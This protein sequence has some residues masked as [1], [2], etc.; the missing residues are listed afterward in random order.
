MRRE[1]GSPTAG[2]LLA[3]GAYGAWGVSPVYWKWVSVLPADELLAWRAVWSF[4]ITFA[5]GILTGR[6]PEARAVLRARHQL[7]ALACTGALLAVNWLIFV[8]AV[9]NDQI[10]ATS[11]GYYMSPLV[12]VTLGVVVLGEQLPRAQAI[13]LGI[14]SAG[15]AYLTFEHGELPWI[16]LLLPTTFGVYG[17]IRKIAP[18]RPLVG[19]GVEMVLLLPLAL[20]YVIWLLASGR[21]GLLGA[22]IGLHAL[23]AAS[24]LVTAVPLIWFVAAAHRLPLTTLG[25]FQYLAPSLSLVIAVWLYA[26]PFT[27]V[28]A[29]TFTG[30]WIALAIYTLDLAKRARTA[31]GL[32]SLRPALARIPEDPQGK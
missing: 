24:G 12:H 32:G 8:W 14:A 3:L 16:A 11:L 13:A 25:M 26:E 1:E 6:A 30:I 5:F 23:V 18:V 7:L 9:Q 17:L 4:A 27:R 28:Q 31:G 22:G 2:L 10:T 21:S 19:F 29:V 15:V 20:G